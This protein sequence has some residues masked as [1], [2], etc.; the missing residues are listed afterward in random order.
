MTLLRLT[1]TAPDAGAPCRVS[2]LRRFLGEDTMDLACAHLCLVP[3]DSTPS[4]ALSSLPSE[5]VLIRGYGADARRVRQLWEQLQRCQTARINVAAPAAFGEGWHNYRRFAAMLVPLPIDMVP[6]ADLM[7]RARGNPL[8]RNAAIRT[9][10][11]ANITMIAN[12]LRGLGYHDIPWHPDAVLVDNAARV[13][14]LLRRPLRRCGFGANLAYR[15][16]RFRAVRTDLLRLLRCLWPSSFSY[17]NYARL[18]RLYGIR[19][20]N[21]HC[22]RRLRWLQRVL[23]RDGWLCDV[24]LPNGMIAN[25]TEWSPDLAATLGSFSSIMQQPGIQEVTRKRGRTVVTVPW[26]DGRGFLK[27]H[28][29]LSLMAAC[30]R[31]LEGEARVS[32]ARAEWNAIRLLRTLGIPSIVPIAMGER[33]RWGFWE[34]GSFLLTAELTGA[35]SLEDVF[36]TQSMLSFHARVRLARRIGLL[37]RRLHSAGLV[38]RDFYLG[39]IYLQ[40]SLEGAYQLHLLDLQRVCVGAQ[41]GN[42]WSV[43]DVSALLF[44]SLP[45]VSISNGDRLRFLLAYFNVSSLTPRLRRFSR[46]VL[47]KNDR[48]ARHTE[49]LLARR[50]ARGELPP[51]PSQPSSSS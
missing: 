39:H 18:V 33:L 19:S 16:G 5:F 32:S 1:P 13:C 28:T 41:L 14:L 46:R 11:V 25:G 7:G 20:S 9:A 27:R 45:I 30:R 2:A 50:R 10:F 26:H 35:R 43:K 21:T 23:V 8:R 36:S 4:A 40:G 22:R 48:V 49:K 3:P 15:L 47:D 29:P 51:L 44:S 31:W 24:S 37:A 38:H 17:F 34:R 12:N 42:R 6:I